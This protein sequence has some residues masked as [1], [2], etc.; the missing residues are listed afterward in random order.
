[1]DQ[2]SP[3]QYQQGDGTQPQVTVGAS[4][5]AQATTPL[6]PHQPYVAQQLQQPMV[7]SPNTQPV[8]QFA[9]PSNLVLAKTHE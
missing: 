8:G 2:N 3:S 1:M 5:Y 7:N 6:Q 9:L 4:S